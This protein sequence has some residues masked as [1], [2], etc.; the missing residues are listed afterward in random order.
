MPFIETQAAGGGG[1]GSGTVTN[2]SSAN[3]GIAV[4]TPTTT[5]VLTLA[6]L[7]VIATD[8]PPAAAWSNNSKKI[9]NL[10][11]GAAAQDAAAF[12][13]IPTA[14]PP[15]GSAGGDLTGTYP[16]P[17]LAAAGGGAAGPIGSTSVIPVVTVDAKGRV[18][19]LTSASPTLDTIATANATAANVSM[20][21]HKITSLTEGAAAGE[22]STYAATP[23]G[24]LTTTGDTLYASSAHTAARLAVG[25]TGQVVGVASGVP[26]WQN[27]VAS[28][29]QSFRSGRYTAVPVTFQNAS[30]GSTPAGLN[31]MSVSAFMVEYSIAVAGLGVNVNS[32]VANAVMRLGIYSDG[33]AGIPTTLVVDAGTVDC[34]T[35]TGFVETTTGLPVTL[36][37]GVYWIAAV[38]QTANANIYLSAC[39]GYS[40]GTGAVATTFNIGCYYIASV[41]G[42]LP[43]PAGT[44]ADGAGTAPRVSI[45]LS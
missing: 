7:D 30:T 2:V 31:T 42:A 33:G 44:V 36:T 40:R 12:G 28:V 19:A 5:P 17:T 1:G 26:A 21:S 10:A 13:Q 16:N 37:P 35:A 45:R 18:T 14:L 41:S 3:T 34:H 8:G 22:A 38:A 6:T 39:D 23:A 4:A 9:T 27:P 43:T 32:T 29:Y 15:N 24:I 25:A 11:N 20:N